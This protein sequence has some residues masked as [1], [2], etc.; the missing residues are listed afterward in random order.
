M[1]TTIITGP[2]GIR[3]S[4]L[5]ALLVSLFS[6]FAPCHVFA[7]DKGADIRAQIKAEIVFSER[8]PGRD[9]Q[10]HY[11]AN[12]G[13]SCGNENDWFH[14]AD[15]GR[16]AIYNPQTDKVRTLIKDDKG[17]FRDPRVSYDAKKVLFSYR[18]GGTHH[19]NLYEINVDGSGLTQ[20]T[21]G[22]WDDIEPCYLPDGDIIF[23]STR[24]K[25]YVLCWQSSVPVLFRCKA[26]GSELRQLSSGAN[27]E[28]TPAVLP[29][30]R[31]IYT[32]WEYVDRA[33]TRFHQLWAIK[34]DGTGAA[35]YF[36]NM[37]PTNQVYIDARPIP[38]T[39]DVLYVNSG[40]CSNEHAGD[41]VVLNVG[42][43]P[44][45]LSQ[46]K[47]LVVEPAPKGKWGHNFR[48]PY[49]VSS[50]LILVAKGN[51]LVVIQR[52]GERGVM[53][54]VYTSPSKIAVHDP[55]LIMPRKREPVLPSTVDHSKTT[56]TLFLTDVNIG[57]NMKGLKR[58]AIKKLL[59]MEQLPKPVNFHGGGSTPLAHGGKWTL[60]RILGT[61]PVE[62]DGSAFFEVP[63]SRSIYLGLLDE[64]D[65]NV[66]QMRSFITV[67]PGENASCI[68]CH[69]DRLM[70]PP[71]RVTLAARRLPSQ[72]KPIKGVP[73]IYDFPRDIQ[74]ILD[75]HCTSCHN[76]DQRDGGV[77]LT[78]DH[79]PT[80]SMSYYNLML[81]RQIKD[82]GGMHWTGS[83]NGDGRG[84]PL[85]NDAPYESFSSAAPLMKKI[86]G[87]HYKVQLSEHE[88]L[89][90]R[91]WLDSATPYAGTYAAFGT[92]QIGG[93]WRANE[94]LREMTNT[95]PSTPMAK[96]AMTRRCASCHEGNMPMFITDRKIKLRYY[97]FEG[98][99]RPT[100]RT[101]RHN[102]FNLS[103]PDQSLALMAPLSKNAGGYAIGKSAEA[104]TFPINLA[105][106]P[107][108]FVHPVIFESKDDP[109]FQAVL[110]HI[111]AA[112]NRLNT[113]K[114]FDMPGFQPRYDYLRE[115]KRYGV[116]E[117]DFDLKNPRKVDAY[118]LDSI[119]FDLFYPK[120]GKAKK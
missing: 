107:Q 115:M 27:V 16:L 63:A 98:F 22:D 103:Q 114:R 73:Q 116:L 48:D 90:I 62:K 69:E 40:H 5:L 28:N 82:G 110:K 24:C 91:R 88:K 99:Q 92:G 45:D 95:W 18:K 77:N 120:G 36:G 57:R 1:K 6:F 106:K 25:R 97:D 80:Y 58:G 52:D 79:G 50:S 10:N 9:Y 46:A 11:Y 119:Y 53:T 76:A 78:G 100:F 44:D 43:G 61:V 55:Q 112:K 41:L 70:T 34:P 3:R 75:Q 15:G 30:G 117:A 108:A 94:P 29:D 81:H 71:T 109:D 113:I 101:S 87:S 59:V 89:V 19:Y 54:S 20:L 102:I 104:E 74:P 33:T 37:H 35:T 65:L 84:E 21:S 49:P 118:K 4:S 47:N 56:G 7:E 32:R 64:N 105:E 39:Q 12:I 86:N 83:K 13:Y 8:H 31:I 26:D 68:G 85:G 60:N 67:M 51:D 111:E 42:N 2:G 17:A 72:V 93:W 96:D 23:C 38:G 14:G 66:K